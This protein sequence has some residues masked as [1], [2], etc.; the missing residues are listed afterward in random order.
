MMIVPQNISRKYLQIWSVQSSASSCN[1]VQLN[2]IKR[3]FVFLLSKLG[4]VDFLKSCL[5]KENWKNSK[6]AFDA[7]NL[8]IPSFI[9]MIE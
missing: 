6:H 2:A 1:Y 7:V 9:G 8:W 5:D 4:V 3:K